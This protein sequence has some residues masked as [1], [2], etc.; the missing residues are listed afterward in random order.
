MKHPDVLEALKLSIVT[1]AISTTLGVIFGLPAAILLEG[2]SFPGHHSKGS[3][4]DGRRPGVIARI[5]AYGAGREVPQYLWYSDCL[6]H[7]GGRHGT[8][9]RR[10]TFLCQHCKVRIGAIAKQI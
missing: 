9:I 2:T 8:D 5:W 3:S 10:G 7:H 1:T 4:A 6:Y